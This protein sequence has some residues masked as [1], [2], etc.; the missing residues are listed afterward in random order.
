MNLVEH[1]RGGNYVVALSGGVDSS[2]VA[3]AAYLANPS[4]LAVTVVDESMPAEDV[5]WAQTIAKKIGIE[6]V[7]LRRMIPKKVLENKEGRCY[8]CKKSIFSLIKRR[9]GERVILDG[10]NYDDLD[11]YRPGMQAL[12]ELGVRSPLMEIGMR[13]EDVRELA[14]R[15]ELPN[16]D[17]ESS[18]C[19]C[20]RFQPNV[21]IKK[22]FMRVIDRVENYIRVLGFRNVRIRVHESGGVRMARIE[23][24][25]ED[26]GELFEKAE[27]ISGMLKSKGFD[28]VVLDPEGYKRGGGFNE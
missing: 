15:W 20:S 16:W 11:D 27:E 23:V 26:V 2:V 9:F 22:R 4:S 7:M 28:L 24:N 13:K 6:H 10:S 3:K 19:L 18:A 8:Y 1:L 21:K 17:R 25:K 12:R 14:K 5:R